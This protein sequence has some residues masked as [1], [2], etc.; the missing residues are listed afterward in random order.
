MPFT[1]TSD[2]A[3]TFVGLSQQLLGS[4]LVGD[5][6]ESVTLGNGDNIDTFVLLEH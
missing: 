4:P 3:Q 5:T 2:L 6:L 1:D